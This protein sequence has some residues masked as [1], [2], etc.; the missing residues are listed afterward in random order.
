M[1]LPPLGATELLLERIA[2]RKGHFMPPSLVESQVA[3]LEPLED[4]EL[5]RRFDV[6]P[7]LDDVVAAVADALSRS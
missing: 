6:A 4:D 2:G 5:G 3:T 7:P 1:V